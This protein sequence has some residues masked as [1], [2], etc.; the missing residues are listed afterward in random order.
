MKNA[1]TA[2]GFHIVYSVILIIHIFTVSAVE[3]RTKLR[4]V[5]LDY[6]SE[7]TICIL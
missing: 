1:S 3:Y 7:S 2:K 5:N 4:A 6:E